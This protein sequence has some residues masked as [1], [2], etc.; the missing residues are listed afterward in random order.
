MRDSVRVEA[1]CHGPRVEP[2]FN[3]RVGDTV[4]VRNKGELHQATV[5]AL[6][7]PDWLRVEIIDES[8]EH[9]IELS[10]ASVVALMLET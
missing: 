6:P 8:Q 2:R 5:R 10:A 7:A 3:V 1:C 4:L 9:E